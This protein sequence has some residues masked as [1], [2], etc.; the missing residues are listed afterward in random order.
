VDEVV[1]VW[2]AAGLVERLRSTT[3]ATGAAARGAATR[4]GGF[5]RHGIPTIRYG[6]SRRASVAVQSVSRPALSAAIAPL[7]VTDGAAADIN[8]SR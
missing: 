4:A 8:R 1:L 5:L 2:A 7:A 6:G 3:V